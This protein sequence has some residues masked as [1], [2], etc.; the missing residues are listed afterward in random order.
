MLATALEEKEKMQIE[1]FPHLKTYRQIC[2][3]NRIN[4]F[5]YLP[6]AWIRG[7]NHPNEK[8]AV[9]LA[10]NERGEK[11]IILNLNDVQKNG[12]EK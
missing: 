3:K 2:Y 9:F 6:P 7:N 4:F 5:V 8:V 12:W 11:L 10:E 1:V